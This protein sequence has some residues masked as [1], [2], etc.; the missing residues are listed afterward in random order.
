MDKKVKW[1]PIKKYPGYW[2]SEDGRVW[3]K[4]RI[5]IAGRGGS[6]RVASAREMP[7]LYKPTTHGRYRRVLMGYHLGHKKLQVHRIVAEHFLD[8]PRGYTKMVVHHKDGNPENNHYS[9]L[10]WLTTK[11]HRQRH[12][13]VTKNF[14]KRQLGSGNTMAKLTE[15][16][17]LEIY[18]LAQ[19]QPLKIV[20]GKFGIA[21]S[22]V[23]SIKKGRSWKHL[24]KEG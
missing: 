13:E 23:C 17:V 1:K 8:K 3:R 12:P 2:I 11:Q 24:T 21:V 18:K 20:G 9:N 16:Q 19:T 7:Y 10:E 6:R 22:T 14:R 4:E 5:W 15:K